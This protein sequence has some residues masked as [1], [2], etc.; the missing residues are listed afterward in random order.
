MDEAIQRQVNIMGAGA[1]LAAITVGA[2]MPLASPSENGTG[3]LLGTAEVITDNAAQTML[4]SL[5]LQ[6]QLAHANGR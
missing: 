3:N 2:A 4:P 6:E 5:V 1:G